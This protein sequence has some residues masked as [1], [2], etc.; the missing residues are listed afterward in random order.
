V[1]KE[2]HVAPPGGPGLGDTIDER[3]IDAL[4]LLKEIVA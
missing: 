1:V 2:G 4:T 3:A